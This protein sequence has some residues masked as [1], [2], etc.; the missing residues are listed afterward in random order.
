[1]TEILLLRMLLGL[2][3][4]V[5]PIAS[6]SFIR[7]NFAGAEAGLPIG[8]YIAGQ[9]LGPAAGHAA[10]HAVDRT[11]RMARHVRDHRI[12][13]A[14]VAARLAVVRAAG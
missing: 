1:M 11:S 5:G 6:M 7:R 10:G 14:A 3:E 4:S 8:I 9:N 13:R 2:A 12:G